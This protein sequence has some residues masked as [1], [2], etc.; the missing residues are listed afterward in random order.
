VSDFVKFIAFYDETITS[1][2]GLHTNRTI[3]LHKNISKKTDLGQ[4]PQGL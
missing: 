4:R 3:G 2:I 1:T